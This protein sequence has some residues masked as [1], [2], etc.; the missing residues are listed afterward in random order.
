M[1]D[2]DGAF[3]LD[4]STQISKTWEDEK[5]RH[6]LNNELSQKPCYSSVYVKNEYKLKILKEA[7]L[8]HRV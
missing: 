5:I 6:Y 1:V 4:T 2:G 8:V 7:I 3:F